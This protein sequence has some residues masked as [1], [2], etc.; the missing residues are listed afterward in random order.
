MALLRCFCFTLNNYTNEEVEKCHELVN[1]CKYVVWGYEI[2]ESGTPHLQ[3]YAE[4]IKRT[5]FA[6]IKKILERAHIETRRGTQKEAAD[7]CKKDGDFVEFG[8][9]KKQGERGD[10]NAAKQIALDDGMRGVARIVNNIQAIKVA[11]KFLEYNEPER[12]WKPTVVWIWGPT[13]SGKSRMARDITND[14][15]YTKNN[16][17]KWWNG[18]DA[19]EDVIIDDFRDSWWPITYICLIPPFTSIWNGYLS[20]SANM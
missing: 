10:L 5:R 2:G 19:H 12:D 4:L 6:S 16:G 3:G 1:L 8:K 13:G 7:Y 9:M 14:D 11:E 18:Y 20:R 15:V 17:T